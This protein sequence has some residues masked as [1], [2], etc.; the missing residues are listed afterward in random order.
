MPVKISYSVLKNYFENFFLE[1]ALVNNR[2]ININNISYLLVSYCGKKGLC[3]PYD[4][5]AELENLKIT[6]LSLVP[7]NTL[8]ETI[9]VFFIYEIL[10]VEEMLTHESEEVR[11]WGSCINERGY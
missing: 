8:N 4:L 3:I 1:D 11:I 2:L 6:N 10:T 7:T 9:K 5:G